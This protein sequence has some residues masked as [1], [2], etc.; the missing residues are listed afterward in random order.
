MKNRSKYQRKIRI[1]KLMCSILMVLL[2]C[3]MPIQME[4]SRTFGVRLFCTIVMETG[5]EWSYI[6]FAV[7]GVLAVFHFWRILR[8]VRG[9]EIGW[10]YCLEKVAFGVGI[11]TPPVAAMILSSSFQPGGTVMYVYVGFVLGGLT[12]LYCRSQ[13]TLEEKEEELEEERRKAEEKR[14]HQKQADYFPGRYP[15]EFY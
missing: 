3:F 11:L 13:E 1:S 15:K 9:R 10:L 5:W 12:F 8:I 7:Y 4:G 14:R 6:L 2:V